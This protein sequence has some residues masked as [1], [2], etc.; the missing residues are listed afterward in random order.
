MKAPW[1][2]QICP[3]CDMAGCAFCKGRGKLSMHDLPA[4]P[5]ITVGQEI[6]SAGQGNGKRR[7]SK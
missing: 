6:K 2:I 1:H 4:S 5:H 3:E 7:G